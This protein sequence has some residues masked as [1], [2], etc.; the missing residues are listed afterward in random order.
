M[1]RLVFLDTETTSLDDTYGEVWEIGAI[2]RTPGQPDSE[3]L[4]QI[5]PDL[6][7]ANPDSLR[8]GRFYER[9]LARPDQAVK[10]FSETRLEPTTPAEIAHTLAVLLRGAHVV[11]AV[12]DFDYRFLRR[13]LARYGQCWTAH[14]H[15]IDVET[16]A[17]GWLHGTGRAGE[18]GD[19]PW[20]SKALSRAV[21]VDPAVFDA[22]TAL[23]DAR[24]VRAIHDAVTGSIF[25]RAAASPAVSGDE[26]LV[27]GPNGGA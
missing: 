27:D 15:L 20:D 24:W 22:H 7:T 19:L 18:V 8:I 2:A 1:S 21:G 26:R 9:R 4:W 12:P 10:V 5:W 25:P 23:G 16:L 3:H 14:Y 6:T 11:G 17:V 13:L